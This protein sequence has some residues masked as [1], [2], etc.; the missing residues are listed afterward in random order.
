[1]QMDSVAKSQHAH[2]TEAELVARA[3]GVDTSIGLSEADAQ[4]R[5][6]KDGR[7]VLPTTRGADL[8]AVAAAVMLPIMIVEVWKFIVRSRRARHDSTTRGLSL[9]DVRH[10][11]R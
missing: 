2:A 6:A 3:L 7:N 11:I 8:V 1:M 4:H 9:G 5:L 10:P